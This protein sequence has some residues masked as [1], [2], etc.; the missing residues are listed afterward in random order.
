MLLEGDSEGKE[1][2]LPVLVGSALGWL[3]G[4]PLTLGLS[5][6]IDEGWPLTDGLSDGVEVGLPI[7]VADGLSLGLSESVPPLKN[8]VADG[9][10]VP[11]SRL[12]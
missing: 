9:A 2:G 11:P 3:D 8:R 7:M 10:L 5:D 6:G 4:I 1:V 12:K